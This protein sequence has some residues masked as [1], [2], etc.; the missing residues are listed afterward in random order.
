MR[1]GVDGLLRGGGPELR[2]QHIA[3][4]QLVAHFG[5][6]VGAQQRLLRDRFLFGAAQLAG[7][8]ALKEMPS[9]F[10]QAPSMSSGSSS[11]VRR[12]FRRG[13]HRSAQRAGGGRRL[14]L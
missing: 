10:R 1:R 4:D 14:R 13:L 5:V 12:P 2:G 3:G 8:V 9:F 6:E 11:M 7:S